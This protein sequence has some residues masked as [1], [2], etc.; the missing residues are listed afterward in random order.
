MC[1]TSVSIVTITQY[2]RFD[3]LKNLYELILLQDYTTI[4]EWIIVEGS[5]TE[6]HIMMNSKQILDFIE[7]VQQFTDI[8]IIYLCKSVEPLPLSNLRNLGN[9]ACS[10]DIIVCMDDDDYYPPKRISHAVEALNFSNY[11]IAGCSAMYMYDF[12]LE[13]LYKFR[14]Y[15]NYHSTNNCMA[16]THEYLKTHS[17]KEGLYSGE[18][19]SFTN[20]FT[21][22]MYQLN[23]LK[24]IIVSSHNKNTYNKRDIIIKETMKEENRFLYEVK[25][26]NISTIIPEIIFER[27]RNI[28]HK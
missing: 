14:G 20:G 15:H 9:N 21:E 28:F 3:C 23:P 1:I 24:C 18:E 26:I 17:H 27:M 4:D 25:Q 11:A 19:F 7:K 13:K 16:F 6:E 22:P 2:S 12:F 5:Q 10:G 8:H